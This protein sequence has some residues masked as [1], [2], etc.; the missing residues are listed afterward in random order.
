[1]NNRNYFLFFLSL[2]LY[3]FFSLRQALFQQIK[4]DP[5]SRKNTTNKYKWNSSLLTS[6]SD[7]HFIN[8][9]NIEKTFHSNF[10]IITDKGKR[11]CN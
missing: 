7:F 10:I 11:L 5:L 3:D 8:K 1:M 6:L 2:S 4:S 9:E